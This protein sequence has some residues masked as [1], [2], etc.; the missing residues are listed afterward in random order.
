MAVVTQ[1]PEL[2]CRGNSPDLWV[3][4]LGLWHLIVSWTRCSAIAVTPKC[5]TGAVRRWGCQKSSANAVVFCL[6]RCGITGEV[7]GLL[8]GL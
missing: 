4:L 2:L 7:L 6:H 5:A 1:F 3:L 8:A